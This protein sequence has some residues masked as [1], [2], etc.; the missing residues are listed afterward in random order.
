MQVARNGAIDALRRQRNLQAKQEVIAHSTLQ[1]AA[2]EVDLDLL[3]GNVGDDQLRMMFTCCHP[4]LAPEARVAL[5]LK[6]L[7]GFGVGEIARA[8]LSPEPTIAQRIVRAKRTIRDLDVPFSVPD[9]DALPAR[10]DSVLEVLYLLFNEGYNAHAGEDLIRHDLVAEAIRLTSILVQHPA[11]EQPR[12]HALLAL[13]LLQASRLPARTDAAGDLLTLE[14]QD[15]TRWDRSLIGRGMYELKQAASGSTI[16]RYHLEAGIAATHAGATSYAATDWPLILGYY[17]LLV[18]ITP[19]PVVALNRAVAVTMVHGSAAGLAELAVIGLLP[20][21]QKYY[22]LHATYAHFW[23]QV[24][25]LPRAR[26]SY[27]QALALTA[28]E[29]ERRFLQRKI[30]AC[31]VPK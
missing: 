15:R 2:D 16:S 28:S 11:G 1:F 7:G 25:D 4:A 20:A 31:I 17:D 29:P 27:G 30:A 19:S 13:M 21:M 3:D 26:A 9:A 10:L 14:E 5:A 22:L 23:Q 6:T 12:V 24:G 18:Q 8:F